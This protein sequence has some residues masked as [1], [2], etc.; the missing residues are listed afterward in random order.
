MRSTK[1]LLCISRPRRLVVVVEALVVV[2]DM[3][4]VTLAADGDTL[5]S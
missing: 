1:L 3:E 4:R 5:G 2:A